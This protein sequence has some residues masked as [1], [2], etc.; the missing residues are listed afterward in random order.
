MA[1]AFRG[2]FER[3]GVGDVVLGGTCNQQPARPFAHGEKLRQ[4]IGQH[5][6]AGQGVQHVAQALL[7]AQAVVGAAGVEQ[8]AVRQALAELAQGIGWGV[9][10]E[11]ADAGLVLALGR[12]EQLVSLIAFGAL[13]LELLLEEAPGA[14]AVGDGQLG[15]TTPGVEWFGNDVGQQRPARRQVRQV[16]DAHLQFICYR[17]RRQA[18]RGSEAEQ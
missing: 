4:G 6:A 9:D 12:G 11:Q 13:Q 14:V 10:H 5:G 15:A 3:V 18:E 16:A 1:E 2:A 7:A 17:T 8:Q